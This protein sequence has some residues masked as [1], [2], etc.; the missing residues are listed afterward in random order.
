[1]WTVIYVSPN[2]RMAKRIRDRLD[3]EGFL[4][5]IRSMRF[6]GEQ[7]EVLVPEAELQE[8]QEVLGS[9]L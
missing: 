4:V 2:Q 7:Y 9:I 8:V 1:M 5:K 3:L 6:H